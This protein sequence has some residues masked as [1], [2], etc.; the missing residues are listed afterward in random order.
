MNDN[1]APAPADSHAAPAP[2]IGYTASEPAVTNTALDPANE[3]GAPAPAGNLAVRAPVMEYA[4]SEAAVTDTAP[5]PVSEHVAPA[6]AVTYESRA[7]MIE[8]MAPVPA[9]TDTAPV[10]VSEHVTLARAVTSGIRA[11]VIEPMAPVFAVTNTA[12]VPVNEHLAPALA[13]I[14]K[15]KPM[16]LQRG[17]GVKPSWRSYWRR[18]QNWRTLRPSS[19]LLRQRKSRKRGAGSDAEPLTRCAVWGVGSAGKPRAPSQRPILPALRSRP[20]PSGSGRGSDPTATMLSRHHCFQSPTMSNTRKKSSSVAIL[21]Q[22][23]AQRQRLSQG[24]LH[25]IRVKI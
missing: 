2:A 24:G 19:K 3:H 12:P 8:P 6:P 25:L 18:R 9:V 22:V 10:P 7:L 23:A 4:A 21:A 16:R 11:P 1:V 20:T 14:S 5:V 13:A 17:P 15:L